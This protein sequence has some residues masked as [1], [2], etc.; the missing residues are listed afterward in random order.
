MT[1]SAKQA[2]KAK[3]KNNFF[4][5]NLLLP[6][7]RQMKASKV[8][9]VDMP[10]LVREWR[11]LAVDRP[12]ASRQMGMA[13]IVIVPP[14][15]WS[16]V[17]SKGDEAMICAVAGKFLQQNQDLKVG[18]VTAV[19]DAEAAARAMG[20]EPLPIWAEEWSLA[21]ADGVIREFDPDALLVF[22]ADVMDG[23]YGPVT[24][25]RILILADLAARRG[26]KAALIGF[27]FNGQPHA[28]M[29][30]IFQHK[31]PE[32]RINVRDPISH[33]R[34][35]RFTGTEAN[36]VA[37]SAFMLQPEFSHAVEG[38]ADWVQNR[39]AHGDLVI[40][41]NLHPL[42]IRDITPEKMTELISASV[43]ALQSVLDSNA[44]SV[45]FLSH[46]YRGKNSDDAC[47]APIHAKLV[48][49]YGDRLLY[50]I[51][52]MSAAEL[53]AAAGLVD[54]VVTG[55]MHLAIASLGMGVPVAALTY[56]DKFQ[57]LMDHFDL[58][59]RFMISADAALDHRQIES[60]ITEFLASLGDLRQQVKEKLPAVELAS[61]RN[62]QGFI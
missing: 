51:L 8:S 2:I 62:L 35:S 21:H 45:L 47:L 11:A 40:V 50:P 19:G 27:S 56:Q 28:S 22:G 17:G 31:S 25:S 53:K 49:K 5:R 42:L 9:Y 38:I 7:W 20:F 57:G 16:L 4:I 13:R 26:A 43:D 32:L 58:P 36:L 55:R 15:P 48:A 3:L 60:M 37:D 30:N 39:K 46:D 29:R 59:E 41:Y 24:P 10:R 14:D 6:V 12:C 23:Y 44:V 18:I 1:S 61:M 34:Y 52:K 33:A 54:G